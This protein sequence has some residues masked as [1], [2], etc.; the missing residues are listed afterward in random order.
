MNIDKMFFMFI[1]VKKQKS[2]LMIIK[3]A[4]MHYPGFH[5]SCVDAVR[6]MNYGAVKITRSITH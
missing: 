6:F 1:G 4:R 3:K 5:Y 2:M